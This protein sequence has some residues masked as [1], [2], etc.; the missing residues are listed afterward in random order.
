MKTVNDWTKLIHSTAVEKGWW[1][2]GDRDPL[3]VMMLMVSELAEAAEEVRQ[4]RPDLYQIQEGQ[5]VTPDNPSWK[6]GLKPEGEAVE[7]ADC[8]IRI[9][10]YAGRKGWD[11][12]K[13]LE[14]KTDYNKTRPYR[15][16]NKAY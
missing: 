2:S 12:E 6:G 13:I 16:G 14:L 4:R 8:L 1:D 7:V 15:H 9:L 11:M 10:D 3:S 5:V